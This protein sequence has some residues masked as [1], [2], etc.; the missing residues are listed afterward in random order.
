M[1]A[2]LQYWY[3][4]KS[5]GLLWQRVC[6]IVIP[7]RVL[8]YY[9]ADITCSQYDISE[10]IAKLALDSNPSLTHLFQQLYIATLSFRVLLTL[11]TSMNSY[12]I[13]LVCSLFRLAS[14]QSKE[15]FHLPRRPFRC[16][17]LLALQLSAISAIV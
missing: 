10:K 8:V 15:L 3:P 11:E 1:A 2:S 14:R 13:Y 5:V 9:K 17:I 4:I 6:S 7:L 12:L 16:S